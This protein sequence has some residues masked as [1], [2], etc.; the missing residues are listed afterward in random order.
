MAAKPEFDLYVKMKKKK[1]V[2]PLASCF[3][4]N[5]FFFPEIYCLLDG[6]SLILET[7]CSRYSGK[8]PG[9]KYCGHCSQKCSITYMRIPGLIATSQ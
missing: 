9:F 4:G 5:F 2:I 1:K 7:I 3:Q 6:E 8:D